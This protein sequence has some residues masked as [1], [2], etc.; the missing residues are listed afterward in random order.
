MQN[1]KLFPMSMF[2]LG[3]CILCGSLYIGIQLE[4]LR[5]EIHTPQGG[6]MTMEE[7]A[8]Y[9]SITMDELDDILRDD[10]IEKGKMSMYDTYRF[11][12]YLEI[13]D[14]LRFNKDQLDL[15]IAYRT[16]NHN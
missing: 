2:F 16:L 5:Q 13:N 9:L 4:S 8:E 12:P 15:Y 7:T 6:L 1:S 11:L 10:R 14:E 3:M